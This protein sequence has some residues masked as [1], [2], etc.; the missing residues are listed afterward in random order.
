MMSNETL[1]N[2]VD[3][4]KGLFQISTNRKLYIANSSGDFEIWAEGRFA[5]FVRP[6]GPLPPQS[7]RLLNTDQDYAQQGRGGL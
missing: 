5:T 7:A 2:A 6:G 4:W 1:A 3:I